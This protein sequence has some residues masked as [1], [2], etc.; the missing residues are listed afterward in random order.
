M[1]SINTFLRDLLRIQHAM[2][3]RSLADAKTPEQTSQ[4]AEDALNFASSL[5]AERDHPCG[6]HNFMGVPLWHF[7]SAADCLAKKSTLLGEDVALESHDLAALATELQA[8]QLIVLKNSA[9]DEDQGE[10]PVIIVD[11]SLVTRKQFLTFVFAIGLQ[12]FPSKG[13]IASLKAELTSKTEHESEVYAELCR[14]VLLSQEAKNNG[15]IWEQVRG[16]EAG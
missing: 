5:L 16:N 11:T 9:E 1:T 14:I 7:D 3:S 12:R 15:A 2:I 8:Y 4:A 10:M 13:D 6:H